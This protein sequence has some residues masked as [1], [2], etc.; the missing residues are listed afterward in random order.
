MNPGYRIYYIDGDHEKST[1]VRS[2]KYLQ[3]VILKLE[4]KLIG[5][6]SISINYLSVICS[7]M[8]NKMKTKSTVLQK[9]AI[10][11]LKDYEYETFE[12]IPYHFELNYFTE[13]KTIQLNKYVL[14]SFSNLLM[15][16]LVL[17]NKIFL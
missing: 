1:R 12:N 8:F 7:L 3:S 4:L 17:K 15:L 13:S 10:F 5:I 16:I 9:S 2:K 6:F 14:F 11:Y